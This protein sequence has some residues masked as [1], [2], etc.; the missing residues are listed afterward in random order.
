MSFSTRKG[1]FSAS[2][3]TNCI[4]REL[5]LSL[6]SKNQAGHPGLK[7]GC[8]QLLK[9]PINNLASPSR[10]AVEVHHELRRRGMAGRF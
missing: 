1:D 4:D 6:E 10:R 2:I 7:M 5:K 8:G 3:F 9:V